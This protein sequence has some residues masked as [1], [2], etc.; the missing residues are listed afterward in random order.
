MINF[1][2]VLKYNEKTEE[3]DVLD[4][5]Q[6]FDCVKE[7][8]IKKITNSKK[9]I[10]TNEIK[11]AT[12]TAN[13]SSTATANEVS[14]I[15]KP[16]SSKK[17]ETKATLK[18][19][20]STLKKNNTKSMLD[21][22]PKFNDF[23]EKGKLNKH[24]SNCNWNQ[25][26]L[27]HNLYESFDLIVYNC[28][29]F[30]PD[31][32]AT[33]Q[34]SRVVLK[35]P[36]DVNM[37][38]LFHG[39]LVHNGAVSKYEPH[40]YSMN[41]APDLRAFAYVDKNTNLK[42]QAVRRDGLPRRESHNMSPELGSSFIPCSRFSVDEPQPCIICDK[43]DT[44]YLKSDGFVVDLAMEY[45]NWTKKKKSAKDSFLDP[46]AGDLMTY[47]WAVFEG[48]NVRDITVVGNLFNDLRS[49]IH[50][51]PD[52]RQIQNPRP[53]KAGRW[54]Y[55]ISTA[56]LTNDPKNQ[57]EFVGSVVSFYHKVL[58]E[59]LQ[60]VKGF[61]ASTIVEGHLL[62]NEGDLV[63]QKPHRDYEKAG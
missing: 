7:S 2:T 40:E 49:I 13:L 46:I 4:F 30:V 50:K 34:R 6:I 20:N 53:H 15:K 27:I 39:N 45:S 38:V 1:V 55:H 18:K 8:F 54:Q 47:G 24:V 33:H 63:E 43:Y 35:F 17:K 42:R 44:S 31:G 62:R 9:K 51:K 3:Y 57:G 60:Y 48:V 26:S 36:A 56:H 37:F 11:E 21:H 22:L 29:H 19:V 41:F 59:R 23:Y 32:D 28:S 61:E 10:K 5:E 58:T 25:Y 12:S 14:Q 52:W 16:K